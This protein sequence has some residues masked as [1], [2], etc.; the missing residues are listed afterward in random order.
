MLQ[1]DSLK[2]ILHQQGLSDQDKLLICLA[3]DVTTAKKLS[4]IR[5]LATK[6]G[7]SEI[8]KWNLSD[9]LGRSRGR[10]V[11]TPNGWI[12]NKDGQKYVGKIIAKFIKPGVIKVATSLRS[13]LTKIKERNTYEFVEDAIKCFEAEFYR[14]A[15]VLSWVGAVSVLYEHVLKNELSAFNTEAKRRN[16]R[17][18]NAK[19]KDDLSRMKERDFLDIL[20]YISVIGK[21]VKREL[22]NCLDLRNSCGHPNTL[23][24]ADSKVSAHLE[25]LILNVFSQFNA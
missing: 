5:D 6:E 21:N 25:D 22:I 24:I 3:V 19:S 10:A 12:L 8:R 4:V 13:H 15:V 1:S 14:A 17:W 18:K 7:L 23:I 9:K 2:D 11:R 16:Q 20:D